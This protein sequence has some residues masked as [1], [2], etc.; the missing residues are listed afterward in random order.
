MLYLH[1][2]DCQVCWCLPLAKE[3]E[4]E[5]VVC[6]C[7]FLVWMMSSSLPL[8]GEVALSGIQFLRGLWSPSE[9]SMLPSDRKVESNGRYCFCNGEEIKSCRYTVREW[10]LLISG[11]WMMELSPVKSS[12]SSGVSSELVLKRSLNNFGQDLE[13]PV[14]TLVNLW[15]YMTW[16][17]GDT[18]RVLRLKIELTLLVWFGNKSS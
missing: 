18:R 1:V 15:L 13:V 10:F 7:K 12:K 11:C 2:D 6:S 4:R 9:G 3:K 14:S 16:Y 5:C 8:K 17:C